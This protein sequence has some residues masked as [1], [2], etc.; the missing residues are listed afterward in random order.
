[1]SFK[2]KFSPK[3][4]KIILTIGIILFVIGIICLVSSIRNFI[5]AKKA[6]D[7]AY[8]RW[9]DAWWNDHTADL[10]DKPDFPGISKFLP[11]VF[12]IFLT[13]ASLV[14]TMIGATPFLSKV[15]IK[16]RNEVKEAITEVSTQKETA[17]TTKK[18]N[19]TPKHNGECKYCGAKLRKDS[20]T[21]EY[22]GK[23]N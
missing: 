5:D 10:N 19:H 3:I 9:H 16:Y 2:K 23:D 4:S 15:A 6:Y 11:I 18:Q 8:D 20:S 12:S 13:I 1:M 14:I 7:S 17:E 22:C 21:C